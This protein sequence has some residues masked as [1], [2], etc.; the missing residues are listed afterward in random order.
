MDA[1]V[2][3]AER[4]DSA[5]HAFWL[6]RGVLRLSSDNWAHAHLEGVW[7]QARAVR[8]VLYRI[9]KKLAMKLDLLEGTVVADQ[10]MVLVIC[11]S[12]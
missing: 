2:D 1:G 12:I 8:N 6:L 9:D 3:P 11:A 5:G 10:P 4:I 7:Q